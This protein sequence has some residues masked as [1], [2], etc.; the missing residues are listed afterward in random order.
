MSRLYAL[1]TVFSLVVCPVRAWSITILAEEFPPLCIVRDGQVTGLAVEI[2][3][4]IMRRLDIQAPI[5]VLSWAR[6]YHITQEQPDVLL[7]TV[8]RTPERE[9]RFIWLAPIAANNWLLIARRRSGL[10]VNSLDDARRIRRIGVYRDAAL[11]EH[12]KDL[13][14]T[15]L[16]VSTDNIQNFKKLFAGRVDAVLING[17]N[18]SGLLQALDKSM[19][20]VEILFSAQNV[21]LYAVFSLGTDPRTVELWRKTFQALEAE[22][23][24]QAQKALWLSA[25]D[26]AP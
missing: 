23:F 4:E 16:D 3:R 26:L 21:D 19:R 2:T 18:L 8:T 22:G 15:N 6:A 11:H 14:F 9:Q 5:E 10:V 1:L 24:I 20:D 25:G 7:L 17:L 12:L 13:G